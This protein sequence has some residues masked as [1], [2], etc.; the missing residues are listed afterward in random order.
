VTKINFA[1]VIDVA[2]HIQKAAPPG[3]IAIT[4][5]AAAYLPGGPSGVS[6]ERIEAQDVKARVWCPR[7]IPAQLPTAPS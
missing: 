3:G 4:E 1:H 6:E 5:T 2:A 7:A